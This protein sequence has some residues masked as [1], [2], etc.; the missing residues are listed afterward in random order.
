[1]VLTVRLE[2]CL[3]MHFASMESACN[4]QPRMKRTEHRVCLECT[5]KS[6]SSQPRHFFS[7]ARG[8]G[9]SDDRLPGRTISEIDGLF[10]VLL[11]SS[12]PCSA[13]HCIPLSGRIAISPA[14]F[15]SR[16]REPHMESEAS[17]RLVGFGLAFSLER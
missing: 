8:Q 6:G 14:K 1:M 16:R 15:S 3:Q 13:V 12:K 5:T 9:A 11:S 10:L 2:K 7:T 17:F 4:G